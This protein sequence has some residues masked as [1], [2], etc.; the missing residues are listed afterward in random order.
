[1]DNN[2]RLKKKPSNSEI[3]KFVKSVEKGIDAF[4]ML[5]A[6]SIRN[7]NKTRNSSKYIGQDLTFNEN[8]V[9]IHSGNHLPD[10]LSKKRVYCEVERDQNGNII[11]DCK[12]A[13]NRQ[14][15]KPEVEMHREIINEQKTVDERI[16]AMISKKGETVTTADLNAYD[17]RLDNSLKFK[18]SDYGLVES[19]FLKFLIISNPVIKT[20][21]IIRHGQ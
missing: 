16:E 20:H 15:N 11:K 18:I 5:V 12:G 8:R 14:K 6:K 3:T 1:M 21:K 2:S 17:I 13:F 4:D 19:Y 7:D 9:C 10:Q